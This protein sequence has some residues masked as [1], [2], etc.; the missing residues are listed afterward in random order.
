MAIAVSV[1]V[2][3]TTIA[4]EVDDRATLATAG[5]TTLAAESVPQADAIPP[6]IAHERLNRARRRS[7]GHARRRTGCFSGSIREVS[8]AVG[9]R[10]LCRYA[11]SIPGASCEDGNTANRSPN[12]NVRL[13]S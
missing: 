10:R 12:R 2:C 9:T 6:A 1:D 13:G 4:I 5:G 3:P 8:Q 7:A 11:H